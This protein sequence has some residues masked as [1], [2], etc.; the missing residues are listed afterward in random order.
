MITLFGRLSWLYRRGALVQRGIPLV[1]LAADKA[2][3]I[4]KTATAGGPC[5]E[6]SNRARLPHRDFVAFAELRRGIAIEFQRS[7][8]R[9]HG[10]GQ[11][12]AVAR[13]AGGDFGDAAHARGVVIAP[14]QQRLA[15]RGAK[16]SRVEAVVLQP[17]RSQLFRV[18]G[19]A[20]AAE[21]ARRAEPGVVDQDD[22]HV[23]C[24]LGR[25]K[26]LDWREFGVRILRVI[27][28]QAGSL[29]GGHR[30]M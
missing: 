25:T 29:R 2:V 17:A 24:A 9:R 27:R 11:H 23:G 4:L 28:D 18:R 16:G 26:L 22:Q 1:C 3:E 15:R 13:R 21:R 5:I 7:R 6:R 20:G 14:G 10:I 30:E 8:E 19:P 12:G